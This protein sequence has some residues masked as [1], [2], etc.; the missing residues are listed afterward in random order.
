MNREE[1]RKKGI[2]TKDPVFNL[3]QSEIQAIKD[4][5]FNEAIDKSFV[6]MLGLPMMVLHD[7]WGYGKVRC[8]RFI[9]QVLEIYDSFNKGYLDFDD[10]IKTLEEE[11][12]IRLMDVKTKTGGK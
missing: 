11:S 3:K 7:Q 12:G 4:K 10:I 9:D 8:E 6:L 5:A 1:R 2:T